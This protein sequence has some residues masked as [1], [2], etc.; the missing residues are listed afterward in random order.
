MVDR[1]SQLQDAVN[2]VKQK[3]GSLAAG[4]QSEYIRLHWRRSC[5]R[6]TKSSFCTM[7]PL[8]EV[9]LR[10]VRTDELDALKQRLARHLPH[11]LAVYGVVSLAARYG[12]HALRPASILVPTGPRPCCFTVIAP[13][14][15]GVSTACTGFHPASTRPLATGWPLGRAARGKC[16]GCLQGSTA[17][18]CLLMFWSLKEHTA[19]DV[20]DRLSRL[21]QLDWNQPML[22]YSVPTVLLQSL[23]SL[24][25][26]GR[27]R[28][29]PQAPHAGHLYQLKAPS[30][31]NAK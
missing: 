28:V 16:Q 15:S 30:I 24:S 7:V 31:L 17:T 12:L 25:R 19:N 14:T 18:Q 11:S 29:T 4:L 10:Q 13:I 8:G 5:R 20:T 22:I 21:P 23:Q 3:K 27:R 26:W 6:P 1:L 2:Q 9:G